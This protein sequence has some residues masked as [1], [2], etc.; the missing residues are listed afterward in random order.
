MMTSPAMTMKMRRWN[1]CPSSSCAASIC[2]SRGS[3]RGCSGAPPLARCRADSLAA[4]S[5]PVPLSLCRLDDTGNVLWASEQAWAVGVAAGDVLVSVGLS[6]DLCVVE[7]LTVAERDDAI[8][9][10]ITDAQHNGW[11]RS[12][13]RTL[14]FVLRL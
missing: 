10:L 8:R 14:R 9:T 12:S 3:W 2:P 11:V 7:G 13:L 4:H 1:R 6:E 5:S